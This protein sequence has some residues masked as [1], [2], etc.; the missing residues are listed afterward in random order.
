V[1]ARVFIAGGSGVIGVRL[2][3]LLIVRDYQVTAMT[4]SREKVA[5]L[6]ALGAVPVVCD[7]FDELALNEAMSASEP[8]IVIHQ[9]TDL[10]D[11]EADLPARGAATMR[12][13]REGTDNLVTAAMAAGVS[14]VLAQSVAWP[15]SGYGARAAAHLEDA[16]IQIGGTVLRYGRWYGPGTWFD[17]VE[18]APPKIHI[19][20]AALLTV[21]ALDQPS[22]IYVAAEGDSGRAETRPA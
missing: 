22:G 20:A 11:D 9:L 19:D 4:R 17:S 21:E 10:P 18:V 16:V 7:V 12:M 3:P 6:S 14:R 5:E 15:L 1:A 2:I 8:D 13:R